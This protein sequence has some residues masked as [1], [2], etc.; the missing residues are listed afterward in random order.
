LISLVPSLTTAIF[1][2][3]YWESVYTPTCEHGQTLVN[4]YTLQQTLS[5]GYN[6]LHF[7]EHQGFRASPAPL[8]ITSSL[9]KAIEGHS[10]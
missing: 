3:P 6:S 1:P 10:F 8:L 5:N 7:N 9:A 2:K 4:L